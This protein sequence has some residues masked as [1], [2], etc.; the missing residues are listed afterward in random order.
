VKKSDICSWIQGYLKAEKILRLQDTRITQSTFPIQIQ[1]GFGFHFRDQKYH[2]E[3]KV[4]HAGL[5]IL[6]SENTPV[7]VLN[8]GYILAQRAPNGTTP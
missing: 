5:D 7:T 8:D 3:H 2:N 1:D 6:A 4:H